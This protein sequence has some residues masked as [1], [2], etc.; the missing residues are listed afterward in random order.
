[1]RPTAAPHHFPYLSHRTLAQ[2]E[3]D[4]ALG[5]FNRLPVKDRR[6]RTVRDFAEKRA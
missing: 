6:D 5:A 2:V 4:E 1:M 3:H